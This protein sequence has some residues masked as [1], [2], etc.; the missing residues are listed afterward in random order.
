MPRHCAGPNTRK[1]SRREATTGQRGWDYGRCKRMQKAAKRAYYSTSFNCSFDC[2]RLSMSASGSMCSCRGRGLQI[3]ELASQPPLPN[4]KTQCTPKEIL[5]R[6]ITNRGWKCER[7]GQ[8]MIPSALEPN[9]SVCNLLRGHPSD[10]CRKEGLKESIRP[11]INISFNTWC[12]KGSGFGRLAS[13]CKTY[14]G[15]SKVEHRITGR[16]C[17][18]VRQRYTTAKWEKN[19]KERARIYFQTSYT[20]ATC[21]GVNSIHP[22]PF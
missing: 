11:G 6:P 15:P 9:H 16:M 4:G 18:T 5:P 20:C 17:N 7:N 8:V 2:S 14:D 3:Y 21:I 19:E 13:S 22:V 10:W 1:K 12:S